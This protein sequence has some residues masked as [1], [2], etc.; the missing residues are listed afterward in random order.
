MT[1]P[2]QINHALMTLNRLVS[3]LQWSAAAEPVN[4]IVRQ[5]FPENPAELSDWWGGIWLGASLSPKANKI[6]IYLNLRSGDFMSRWQRLADIFAPHADPSLESAF[7]SLVEKTG[8]H[9]GIPVGL[10]LV[11]SANTLLGFRIYIGLDDPTPNSVANI[12]PEVMSTAAP[13]LEAILESIGNAFQKFEDQSITIGYDF[14]LQ[15]G[16]LDLA[17][18]RFKADVC[19]H[20]FM[21]MDRTGLERW[22]RE[23]LGTDSRNLEYFESLLKKHFGGSDIDYL[24]FGF[25]RNSGIQAAVYAK[26]Y[27]LAT[28]STN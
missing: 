24:S 8:Q 16:L 21:E 11:I 20:T 25:K 4:R 19:C 3:A 9:R 13:R 23:Q 18:Y 28:Q 2:E 17:P 7:R 22:I 10:A 26:P 27:G 15:D 5:V 12:M 6:K 14:L 1:L